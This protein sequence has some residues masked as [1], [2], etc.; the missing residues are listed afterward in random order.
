MKLKSKS[1]FHAQIAKNFPQADNLA[2]S[3]SMITA[4]EVVDQMTRYNTH[5]FIRKE[6]TDK[7]RNL[8]PLYLRI[9]C[10]KRVE[11]SL[12]KSVTP[13]K[14]NAEK[15]IV[16]GNTDEARAINSFLKPVEVKFHEIHRNLLDKGELLTADILKSHYLGRTE[17]Q[18]TI[19]QAFDYYLSQIKTKVGKGYTRSTLKKYE[20]LKNHIAAFIQKT[21]GFNDLLLSRVDL[22]FIKEFQTYLMTDRQAKNKAGEPIP[23]KGCNFN[24]A[25]KYVKMF[26]TIINVALSFQWIDHNPF[27][28]FKEK[29]QAV[30]QEFLNET[31]LRQIMDKQITIDRLATIRD[32]F[33]FCCFTGLAYADVAKLNKGHIVVGIDS[34][35][36]IPYL[37]NCL[38]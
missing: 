29:F 3:S 8:A 23:H 18:R 24:A 22:L 36:W 28:G 15:Q 26:R 12:G 35:K 4:P 38:D 5:F 34:S 16:V 32:I 25:L 7:V 1:R 17:Q 11:I 19:L 21:C 13:G 37:E 20:Y 2:P 10:G 6:K 33:V 9:F 27:T 31:E 30:E 14:W